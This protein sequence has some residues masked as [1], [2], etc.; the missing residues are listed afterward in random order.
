MFF[1]RQQRR[2]RNAKNEVPKCLPLVYIDGEL[3]SKGRYPANEQLQSILK[4]AEL[5]VALSEKKN[6]AVPAAVDRAIECINCFPV[7]P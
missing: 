3:G 1:Y 2:G 7:E 6:T 4:H 5:D